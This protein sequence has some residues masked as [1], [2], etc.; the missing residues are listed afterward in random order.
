L[1]GRLLSNPARSVADALGEVL[2]KYYKP[3]NPA[4]LNRL[5]SVVQTAEE[6]YFGQWSAEL[7]G[8]LWGIPVPGEFK[9]DQ[10]LFGTSPGP[11]TYLKEPCLDPKGRKEYRSGLKNV[12][13]QLSQLDGQCDDHGRLDTLRRC[14]TVTLAMLNTV[15]SALGEPIQ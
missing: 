9:L 12:L 11:A 5:M 8:K 7:F 6:S 14:V 13:A 1:G 2:E 4:A 10:N 3:R 15:S